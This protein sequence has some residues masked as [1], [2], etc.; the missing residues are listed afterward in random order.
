MNSADA[1]GGQW[2][3]VPH[4]VRREM[5][6]AAREAWRNMAAAGTTESH[7]TEG[8]TTGNSADLTRGTP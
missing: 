8:P 1:M 4:E 2:I 6:R 3:G 7:I 5:K